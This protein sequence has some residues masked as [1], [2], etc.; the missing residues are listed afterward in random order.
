[1]RIRH[2]IIDI[3]YSAVCKVI[4][5]LQN[6]IVLKFQSLKFDYSIKQVFTKQTI[7]KVFLYKVTI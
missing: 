6:A 4:V 3:N 1:M 5:V 7:V 2:C